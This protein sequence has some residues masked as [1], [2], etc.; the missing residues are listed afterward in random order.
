MTTGVTQTVT[1]NATSITEDCV[2]FDKMRSLI[3]TTLNSF[4][5]SLIVTRIQ[6]DERKVTQRNVRE[7]DD[8]VILSMSTPL[9]KKKNLMPLSNTTET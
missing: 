1:L 3:L 8:C 4:Y 5:R 2:K 9:I 6:R 7:L